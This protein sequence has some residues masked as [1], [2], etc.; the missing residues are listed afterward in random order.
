MAQLP[1]AAAGRR[2]LERF[3]AYTA[4]WERPAAEPDGGVFR[5]WAGDAG[6]PSHSIPAHRLAKAAAR[7]SDRA[8]RAMHERL[9]SAYF[10]ESRD[11]SD[12]VTQRELWREVELPEAAFAERDDPEI[13]NQILA[14][15]REAQQGGATGVP[16]V[17]LAGNDAI[18]VGAHPYELYERWVT[19]A[20]PRSLLPRASP[21]RRRPS[22]PPT[23]TKTLPH[24]VS[25]AA[26]GEPEPFADTPSPEASPRTASPQESEP[27]AYTP[28]P[29]G[30]NANSI[31]QRNIVRKAWCGGEDSNL[32]SGLQPV[33]IVK[34]IRVILAQHQASSKDRVQRFA[35]ST[36]SASTE[37]DCWRESVARER[38]M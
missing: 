3:R 8:F 1:A 16:A 34:E 36:S 24:F 26:N 31:R 38:C 21:S 29:E 11:I 20:S 37:P 17:R 22:P 14:E 32:W 33:E 5:P 18:V 23:G 9:L 13:V 19:P 35:L 12:V 25:L 10:S 2:D 28:W 6:P 4:S 30:V 15:H 7:I 27:F